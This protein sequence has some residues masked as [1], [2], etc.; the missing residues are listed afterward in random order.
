VPLTGQAVVPH[1]EVELYAD[2]VLRDPYAALAELRALGPIV[3]LDRYAVWAIPRFDPARAVL[4]NWQAFRSGMGL[5]LNDAVNSMGRES[6]LMSDP[7]RHDV[8]RSVLIDRLGAKA[9]RP[10]AEKIRDRA[11]QLVAEVVEAGEFDAVGQLARVFPVQVVGDLIGLPKEGR[12]DLLQLADGTFNSFGPDNERARAG[13]LAW[14]AEARLL[15]RIA[16]RDRLT[17]GSLG[18]AVYEAADAGLIDAQDCLTMLGTY[19]N[20]SMDTTVNAISACLLLLGRS[21][22]QWRRLRQQ[23]D[24]APAAFEEAVR[25]ESPVQSFSRMT[26]KDETIA[27]TLVPAGRRVLV[28]FGS[29]NRDAERWERADT[30][31]ITRPALQHLGFGFGLHS[32]AGQALAR[33]EGRAVLEAL[34][35]RVE[36]FEVGEPVWHLNNVIRGLESLPVR[37]VTR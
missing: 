6:I 7:P 34:V 35:E 29:A 28:L 25:F 14:P 12:E 2:D 37:V 30:Y 24:L 5:G 18:M 36:S 4:R 31:D 10:T 20:A 8:L 33:I 17:E 3:E 11:R 19:L 9:L 1:S 13:M 21:P 15:A 26:A 32:C 16:T 27:G 22:A 23:P